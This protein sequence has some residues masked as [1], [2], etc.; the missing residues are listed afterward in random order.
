MSKK[1]NHFFKEKKPWSEAKDEL[2]G[3]YLRPYIQK[4]L[5]TRKPIVYVDCFAGKGVFED[6][7]PGSPLIALHTISDCLGKTKIS[8]WT[9]QPFFIDLNYADDLRENLKDYGGIQVISGKYEEIIEELL[10][11][12]AGCNV[13]LYVDP[14]GIKALSYRLFDAFSASKKFNSIELL[15]NM[16]SFGFI[17]EGCRVLGAV[18]DDESMFD[19]L[20]EYD[21]TRL[22]ANEKSMTALNEIAG[23]DYW[24]A[25]IESYKGNE[26]TIYEAEAQ[27]A[28]QY[29][30]RLRHSYT[31][32]LNM[33]LKIKRGQLPK[34]RM[35]HATNHVEG[36]L[37]M[38][39]NI[40]GRWELMKEIQNN[41]QFQ[42]WEENYENEIVDDEDIRN[43]VISHISN[44]TC[45]VRLN[46][47]L[48]DFFMKYGPICS[49]KT[50]K[51]IYKGLVAQRK[52]D[53]R[54]NLQFTLTGR[55]S[56]FFTD[57]IGKI[58]ELRWLS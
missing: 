4:V 31:Y 33:P 35:I 16:N 36:C 22:E 19:D 32:V 14:Y 37:L 50:V 42:L 44:F 45:F 25:I 17:R 11:D 10:S 5:N 23:G 6:G 21:S 51:D 46:L 29:C 34:Y 53:I 55:P 58:M 38:V 1:N 43:K 56:T 7:K 28:A 12:K 54:R 24:K 20:V 47:I 49:R 52:L 3:C 2:L 27:F 40:C 8:R 41:G 39:D 48:A 18:F 57:E 26:I 9:I 13:F 30:E 15:I